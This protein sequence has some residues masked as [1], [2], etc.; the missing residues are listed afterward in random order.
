MSLRS[1]PRKA[2]FDLLEGESSGDGGSLF[3][4]PLFTLSD[5]IEY[6][7]GHSSRRKRRSKVA[8]KKKAAV[9]PLMELDDRFIL[10]ENTP[11]HDIGMNFSGCESR[12]V[13]EAACESTV[14]ETDAESSRVS[15]VSFVELKQRY[16]NSVSSDGNGADD[17]NSYVE[18]STSGKWK[19]ESI[20]GAA[21]LETMD[22]LDWKRVMAENPNL[23]GGKSLTELFLLSIA[24]PCSLDMVMPSVQPSFVHI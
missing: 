4:R 10:S 5:E 17:A 2:S 1:V 24:F 20:G 9:E 6:V 11:Q 3:E 7:N 8:K 15:G 14:M 22:S 21:K 23:L 19:P 13:V 16:V 18:S 12:S